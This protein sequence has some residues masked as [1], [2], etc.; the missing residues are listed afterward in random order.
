MTVAM[1]GLMKTPKVAIVQELEK[2]VAPE[3]VTSCI[4]EIA[5]G[6]K[7]LNATRLTRRAIVTLIH[8]HSKIAR[9]HIEI[10]LDNL[11]SLEETTWLKKKL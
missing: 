2:P 5:W 7:Q 9:K 3:I 11:D 6:M 4:V 8:E 10:V 1:K